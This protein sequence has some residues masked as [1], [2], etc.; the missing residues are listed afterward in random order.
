MYNSKY[1]NKSIKL[2]F[3]SI[4]F[5]LVILSKNVNAYDIVCETQ[6]LPLEYKELVTTDTFRLNITVKNIG[7]KSFPQTLINVTIYGPDRK[8][9]YD[10]FSFI[11][12]LK[13]L[14]V[15][16]SHIFNDTFTYKN[17]SGFYNIYE[18]HDSGTWEVNL[19]FLSLPENE[20]TYTYTKT[21]M[22]RNGECR[23]LFSI[24]ELSKY[25]IEETQINLTNKIVSLTEDL[26][27]FTLAL[28]FLTFIT[29][30]Y[31]F[32]RIG[33]ELKEVILYL[34]GI[35]LSLF[36]IFSYLADSNI[37]NLLIALFLGVV[38]AALLATDKIKT[39]KK[40]YGSYLLSMFIIASGLL[41]IFYDMLQKNILFAIVGLSLTIILFIALIVSFTEFL[42]LLYKKKNIRQSTSKKV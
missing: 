28:L 40:L 25:E 15:N 16:E 41:T 23:F 7:E 29:A 9:H 13:N 33:K 34:S 32:Y 1:T 4:I 26:N 10:Y 11:Y 17:E 14:S 5:I 6:L 22:R 18:I 20:V 3:L 39:M 19:R 31:T 12:S 8:I 42:T 36:L 37:I 24:K 30:L 38:S 21:A 27:R 35:F 2:L